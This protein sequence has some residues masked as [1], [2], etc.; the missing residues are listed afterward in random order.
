MYLGT[1]FHSFLI[2]LQPN[3]DIKID[4]PTVGTAILRS[5]SFFTNEYWYWIAVGALAGFTV[6]FN[7]LFLLMVTYL[8][9]KQ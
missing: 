5:R 4:A 6:L 2:P 7:L 3:K 8:N 9:R 1:D